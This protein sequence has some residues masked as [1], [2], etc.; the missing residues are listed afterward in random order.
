MLVAQ[1]KRKENIAEYI[2]YMYQIEDII[3]AFNFDLDAILESFVKPQLPDA[4]FINQHREWY[5]DLMRQMKAK[6]IVKSG[7]LN[8]TQEILVELSYLHNTL[9]NMTKDE[10]YMAVFEAATPFIDELKSKSDLQ[11]KNQIEIA[12]HGMYMKLLLKLQKKEISPETEEAFDAMRIMLAYLSRG[13]HKMK[14]GDLDFL[15]N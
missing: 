10:K 8:D 2:L 4:S 1:Q 6:N 12:F 7:H 3:R 15:K 9:L 11:D 5:A 14:S 13:Y